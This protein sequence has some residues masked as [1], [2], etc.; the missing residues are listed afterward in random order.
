MICKT[1]LAAMS[2]PASKGLAC[3]LGLM[4][5][6]A[7][8][9]E[10]A[11][12]DII[13]VG[14][15]ID[16]TIGLSKVTT[17]IIDTP[18]AISRIGEDELERRGVNNLSDALRIVPGISLGAGETSWQ[19]NNLVLRGFTTR[20]DTF[21]DG[22]RDYGYYFRDPFNSASLE[23]L[24]GPG[25]TLFGRGSTGGVI[26]QISKTATLDPVTTLDVALGTDDTRRVTADI[27]RAI[28]ETIAVRVNAMTH[29]S[30]VADRDGALQKRWGIAPSIALGLGTPTRAYLSWLHQ[31]EDNRPDYGIPWF[32]GRPAAVKRDNYYGFDS[33]Y[34][35]TNVDVITARIEHDVSDTIRLRNQFRASWAKRS[36]RTSEAVIPAGTPVTTPLTNI[37][38]TRNEFSGYS[39]DRFVQNQTDVTLKLGAAGFRHTIV[40]GVELGREMPRPT[41]IFHE[42]VITTNLA[43]PPKQAFAQARQYVRLRARTR[44]DTIGVYAFDTIE[45]G[46]HWMAVLGVRWDRFD[47]DYRSAGFNAA[48]ATVATTDINRVDK[49]ASLRGSLIY[50][51]GKSS[52]IYLSY[53]NSFNPSAEGIESLISA[54]RSVGQ[55][56]I[57]A[58]PE[59]GRIFELGTKWGMLDDRLLA[60]ASVFDVVK[61]NVRVPDPANP[62]V[63]ANGGRQR[64]RGFEMEA[65]GAITERWTVRAS[66]TYL[67]TETT[68]SDN[69]TAGGSPRIGK[70]LA[71]APKHSAGLQTDYVLVP[72]F[73]IG[74]GVIYQSSRLGQNTNASLLSAPGYTVFEARARY[75][76]TEQLSVQVN[77]YNLTDKLYYDQLHPFHVV[78]GA[79][80]SALLTLSWKG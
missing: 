22:M 28:G 34:L 32:N 44:A 10:G 73:A 48:G 5:A 6:S 78:P 26:H 68:R 65:V 19:G 79:G 45:A 58:D 24:K 20:N 57:N 37:T 4:L 35:D 23:V 14:N 74:G 51:P 33:D 72:R 16:Q 49:K 25:S 27:D 64:V 3:S 54:G 8:S 59:K 18:Q 75:N 46:E 47:A 30:E 76:V 52:S 71:I 2:R 1:T 15:V 63:N 31:E 7:A 12:S 9:A 13:V 60:T 50:K 29:R 17:N 42:G 66:Y 70:Q 80:R 61:S 67:D 55:A 43:N 41:Y 56:N 53:A 11:S 40:A 62:S 38:L 39:T 21:L 69:P 36:F 77:V